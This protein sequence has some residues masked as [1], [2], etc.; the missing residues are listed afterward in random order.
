M[1]H[2]YMYPGVSLGR[3]F[4]YVRMYLVYIHV[5]RFVYKQALTNV[6]MCAYECMCGWVCVET[7]QLGPKST[8]PQATR[9]RVNRRAH[10]NSTR[11]P[12]MTIYR[13]ILK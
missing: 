5:H 10:A 9:S 11:I 6:G 7:G 12:T 3:V 2:T 4:T 1:S 13:N 8:W